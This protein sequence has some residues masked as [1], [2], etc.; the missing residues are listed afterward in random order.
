MKINIKTIISDYNESTG[1]STVIIA[2]DLGEFEGYAQLHDEDK[3]IASRF[4]GCRYAEMR[5]GIKY[6]KAKA[7]IIKY[8]LEPLYKIYNDL[9]QRNNYN[10]DNIG[11]KLLE[12]EIYLLEDEKEIF[13]THAKTLTAR[14][15]EAIESRSGL[16][17]KM[18]EHNKQDNK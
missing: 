12:K 5:A 15:N 14:L 4:A 9:K 1:L 7:R 13:L 8:Q 16:V 2:T 11:I 10:Q 18:M 3:E 6:M 17:K